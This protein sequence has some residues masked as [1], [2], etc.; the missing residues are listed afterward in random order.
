VSKTDNMLA[1][2]W[3]LR[4]RK[5]MTSMQIAEALEISVRTVYRYIDALCMSGVPIVSESG[6]DGGYSLLNDFVEA[7]LF[8]DTD[9]RK[10]MVH[11]ALFAQQAGYPYGEALERSLNKIKRHTNQEQME[12]LIRHTRGFDVISQGSDVSLETWLQQLEQAVGSSRTLQMEYRKRTNAPSEIR[13]IDPYGLVYWKR[14]WYVICYCH[15]RHSIRSFR[16]DR[17][18]SITV[19]DRI[20]QR[21]DDFSARDY[22]LSNMIPE[23]DANETYI[24]VRIKGDP[25]VIDYLCANWFLKNVVVEHSTGEVTFLIDEHAFSTFLPKILISYGTTIQVLEPQS[26]KD[27]LVIFASELV[28]HYHTP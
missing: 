22:F 2:M 3:L 12:E 14:Y 15:L 7:P 16:V 9:E 24:T 19:G 28:Q 17:I 11:A 27:N 5:R 13:D 23:Y 26:L 21:P 20:F 6:H 10:A 1:I 25:E 8:F 18:C 4:S